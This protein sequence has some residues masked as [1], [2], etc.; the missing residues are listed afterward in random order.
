MGVNDSPKPASPGSLLIG[1]SAS[2]TETRRLLANGPRRDFLELAAASGG[3][4]V[5]RAEA[6]RARGRLGRIAGP[7]IRQ[8]WEL[9]RRAQPDDVVFVDGEHIGIPLLFFLAALPARPEARCLPRA[10]ALV[11][12]ARAPVGRDPDLRTRRARRPLRASGG[13]G[14]I[15][16][17]LQL[18]GARTALPGR[19][20]FL[21]PPAGAP[22]RRPTVDRR[23]RLR[24][25][26]LRRAAAR[27]RGPA[28]APDRGG[29]KP[30]GAIPVAD[31]R[32]SGQRR[33]PSRSLS[34]SPS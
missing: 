16:D 29:R 17:R 6:R 33:V 1:V 3:E 34:P 22:A 4:V 24:V 11:V 25:P 20:R 12:E 14:P 31:G 10:R 13:A 21:A 5:Y 2:E 32:D 15:V 7:H 19:H 18:G 27:R 9:A 23:G 28:A 30:L 8:A 26:R